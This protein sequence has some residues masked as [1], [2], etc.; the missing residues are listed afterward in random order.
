MSS[1]KQ[2][3]EK[4]EIKEITDLSKNNELNLNTIKIIK[5]TLDN[6]THEVFE[7]KRLKSITS[8]RKSKS[9]F[10]KTLIFNILTLGILHFV[11]L[12]YPILY[13][14]LYCNPWPA[15]ECDFFLVENIFGQL[16][17]CA[18]NHKKEKKNNFENND[19]KEE[20]II[21]SSLNCNIYNNL[22]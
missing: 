7:D 9:K 22:T 5:R 17:L 18:K 3:E 4:L 12:Y 8:W 13:I 14:K 16:T 21:N 20:K 15:K 11:S 2:N 10:Y 6:N 1:F 19:K